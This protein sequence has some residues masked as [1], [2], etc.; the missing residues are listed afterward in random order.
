M[1][2][3]KRQ[4][5][6]YRTMTVAFLPAANP[7]AVEGTSILSWSNGRAVYRLDMAKTTVAAVMTVLS[8]QLDIQDMTVDS[9]PLEEVVAG[10]Y[11]EHGL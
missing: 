3:I 4:F 8:A 7:V 11:R 9:P 5:D 1:Q 2:K 6:T 10:L